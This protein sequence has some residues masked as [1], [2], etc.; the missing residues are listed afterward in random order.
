M[1]KCAVDELKEFGDAYP[2]RRNKEAKYLEASITKPTKMKGPAP[3]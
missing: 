1:W 2:V 3:K